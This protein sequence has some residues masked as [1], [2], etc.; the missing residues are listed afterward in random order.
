MTT[1]ARPFFS[2]I[3]STLNACEHLQE[4]LDSV[5]RQTVRSWEI[6]VIDGGSR[7]GTLEIIKN[8]AARL[9]YWVSE[10]DRG[11]YDAWNKAIPHVNGRWVM[12]LGA[13][14]ALWE[15]AV[16]EKAVSPLSDL[17]CHI[18]Y[19]RV[20]LIS[21][22]G[23]LMRYEGEEWSCIAQRFRREMCIPHQGVFHRSDIFQQKSFDTSYRYAGDY[24][25]L[26]GE[27]LQRP[28]YFLDLCVSTWRQGGLTSSARH[29][30][31]VLREFRRAR[32]RVGL[33][34]RGPLFTE[35]KAWG[36]YVMERLLGAKSAEALLAIYRK[37]RRS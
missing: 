34:G 30:I 14:D 26:L 24:A 5:Y 20:A 10:P 37:L 15:D 2:I 11:V 25:L 29:S 21:A 6:I 18:A 28:P 33:R 4:C 23:D 13:D 9:K 3:V 36:K 35:T 32:V 7:D 8:N 12:F 1:P 16:F 31:S 27:V 22:K 19:G 17:D